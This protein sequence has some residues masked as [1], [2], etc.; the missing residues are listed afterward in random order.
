MTLFLAALG[1]GLYNFRKFDRGSKI[2]WFLLLTETLN[3]SLA[4]YMAAKYH[5]N[6]AVY[7]VYSL[8]EFSIVCWYF[9]NVIDYFSKYNLGF[10]I[11][12]TGVIFGVIDMTL[13][14]PID[15][16]N[17][18]FL[19]FEGFC[20][21]GMCLFAFFRLLLKDEELRIFRYHHFW[22]ISIF[23]FFW[24][25]TYLSWGL[26]NILGTNFSQYIPI[27]TVLIWIVNIITYGGIGSI[28]LLYP[29]LQERGK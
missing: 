5:N 18:F 16:L 22:F 25:I 4:Q 13:I 20:I 11:G 19:F 17:S 29:K 9:N 7:N 15:M 14:Q 24:C 1:I 28:F 3:E 6:I 12:L 2:I 10:Y 21:I 26:Y 27:I 8:I 23:L